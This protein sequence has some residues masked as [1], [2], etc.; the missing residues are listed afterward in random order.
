MKLWFVVL[1]FVVSLFFSAPVHAAEWQVL[2]GNDLGMHCMDGLDF[3]VFSIL[4]PYNT[5][6]VQ[7]IHNG[8]L[9][10]TNT[11][12]VV[13]YEA[14]ADP[15]G[16]INTTTAN[17]V[18]F[19]E[20][21]ADMFGGQPPD[22]TGLAGFA[23]PGIANIPQHMEFHGDQNWFTGEGVPISPFDD[24]GKVNYYPM[25]KIV[26]RD[27]IGTLLT[28]TK[29]VLP[30]SDEMT[31]SACHLSGS[32]GAA[33]PLVGWRWHPDH[34][35]DI[36]LNILRLHDEKQAGNPAYFQSLA[37][38]GY[39]TNGLYQAVVVDGTAILCARCHQ[40]NALPVT[41]D[42]NT[43]TALT[44]VMH[45]HHGQVVDPANGMILDDSNNRDSCYRC[46]PG[47][48]TRCLRGAMGAAG[49]ADGG[50]AIGCQSCHGTMSSVG[51]V[52]RNGWFEEPK[53][54]SCHTGT[55]LNHNPGPIRFLTVFEPNG[56]ER[57]AVN[58]TF[59]HPTN[60]LYRF[61][62]GHSAMQCSA[63]HG[64]PHAIFPSSHANDNIRNID[65]QGHKGTVVEC[66]ACH[67]S[68]PLTFNGG[69]HGM[70]PVGD[71]PFAVKR[72]GFPE[73][74]FH[75]QVH[76]NGIG[77]ASCRNCHGTDYTGTVL[78][79]S[80]AD[81]TIVVGSGMGT[82]H[83]WRGYQIGC[84][85]CHNGPSSESANT[86]PAAIVVS[87]NASTT[88]NVPVAIPLV[89]DKGTL[90]IVSQ[91][92][93]GTVGLSGS[94][95]TYYPFFNF[96]GTD[97][98]TFAAWDGKK[99]SNLGTVTVTVGEGACM[100]VCESLVPANAASHTAL[101]FWANAFVS[102][103]TDQISYAWNFGDGGSSTN[104]LA[105]H[106]YGINGSYGWSIV[107]SAAGLS[108]TNSGT[109]V[110]GHVQLDSD[111]DGIEDDWEWINFQSLDVAHATS[112]FDMDGQTDLSE[113][114]SG[115]GP[116]DATSKLAINEL[117]AGKII[118][119][120]SS[121]NR[122]YSVNATTSL[123]SVAF[124]PL[125]TGIPATP[126][127]NTYTDLTAT[128]ESAQFYRIDLE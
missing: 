100:L 119:W 114:L 6:H 53:C 30:V 52:S 92:Q 43:V 36:K 125:A 58:N 121:P 81:R 102:N 104:A 73:T 124:S 74:W 115:T 31:C 10:T 35:K 98:F 95:A 94:T 78:S 8:R 72:D 13:T 17:K 50:L 56:T 46:H 4:P 69:P 82:K 84:Y 68:Q 118:H 49:A 9:V 99:D 85:T 5:F 40:S 76:D 117:S 64:S 86:V 113:Y 18:N 88:A 97:T 126:P 96:V 75:G 11:G 51:E 57:V 15:D 87:T 33:M 55:A 112:D 7:V 120:A 103:C 90:R 45:S 71:T 65:M 25:M 47:S 127:E 59:A 27:S 24:A 77:T 19:W 83:F 109:I 1:G 61:S 16:S 111:G 70:H 29:I 89:T 26:V 123:V 116:K 23:M 39:N 12:L 93:N 67:T 107:A 105:Q 106:A 2:G 63:C 42:T 28:S 21:V 62:T 22:D 66:L 32:D 108:V 37:G 38:Q 122:I 54:Q 128:A 48:S 80:Q 41:S 34:A 14:V 60:M 110:V 20:N 44:H 79:R 3:S 101:P 91:A